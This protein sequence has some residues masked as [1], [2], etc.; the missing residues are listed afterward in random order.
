MLTSTNSAEMRGVDTSEDTTGSIE[1]TEREVSSIPEFQRRTKDALSEPFEPFAHQTLLVKPF[2]NET[3]RDI[4][5]Q[6]RKI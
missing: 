2:D 3:H 5:F 6:K 1:P 4:E